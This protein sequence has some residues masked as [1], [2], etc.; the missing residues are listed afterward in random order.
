MG[1]LCTPRPR[2]M[3][4]PDT[5]H[6][7]DSCSP[8]TGPRLARHTRCYT[9]S[10]SETRS[11]SER[12]SSPGTSYSSRC[13]PGTTARAHTGDTSRCRP[14][15]TWP[16]TSQASSSSTPCVR[17]DCCTCLDRRSCTCTS[18]WHARILVCSS[19]AADQ[20]SPPPTARS[21]GTAD[22]LTLY[23]S[24]PSPNTCSPHSQ[25]TRHCRCS[26]C[27]F[28]RRTRYTDLR[29]DR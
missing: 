7:S 26:S 20:H 4:S 27:I 14:H 6:T 8:N 23:S 22:T 16:S 25:C 10:C 5:Q 3:Y 28:Q 11:T 21:P 1:R 12:E 13:P 15:R 29:Q 17:G 2:S 9:R 18:R 19:S 24:P